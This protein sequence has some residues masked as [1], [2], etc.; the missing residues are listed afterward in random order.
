MPRLDMMLPDGYLRLQCVAASD[1]HA[2]KF[3]NGDYR[4]AR[5]RYDRAPQREATDPKR[6]Q[7]AKKSPKAAESGPGASSATWWPA[8]MP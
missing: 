8:S 6:S 5:T 2:A 3:K 1:R 7:S 4:T